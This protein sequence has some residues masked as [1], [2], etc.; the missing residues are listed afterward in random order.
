[1]YK[2]LYRSLLIMFLAL[3]PISAHAQW[4]V[5]WGSYDKNAFMT[6][7]GG[8]YDVVPGETIII[9]VH[10]NT[11]PGWHTY[12][13]NS[14]DSGLPTTVSWE[15]KPQDWRVSDILWPAPK[16]YAM[17][18]LVN[19][20]YEGK[21]LFPIEI[22]VPITA[23]WGEYA[24]KGRVD[25]LA[26]KDTCIPESQDFSFNLWVEGNTVTTAE[27]LELEMHH[28]NLPQ[29]LEGGHT[30]SQSGDTVT[31]DIDLSQTKLDH[32]KAKDIF[33]YPYET[34][35]DVIKNVMS[36]STKMTADRLSISAPIGE[37]GLDGYE[38]VTGVVT[39][40]DY[41]Y[42]ITA[43]VK[44]K[45]LSPL[46]VSQNQDRLQQRE[47]EVTHG[48]L[49]SGI[50]DTGLVFALGMALLGGIVLN[51]M[52]C[53]FPILSIKALGLVSLSG[54]E[55]SKMRLHGLAYMVGVLTCFA[56]L[57]LILILLKESGREIGWGIQ[58]Q[59]PIVVLYVSYI[60]FLVGYSLIGVVE[61]G[62][63]FANAGDRLAGQKGLKG[64][65]FTGALAVVVATP[66]TAPFMGTAVSYAL[67]QDSVVTF[68]VLMALGLGL[69][70]PYTLI[71]FIPAIARLLP[72]PGAWM[73][74]FKQFL[75]F[76]MFAAVVWLVWVLSQ[77]AGAAGVLLALAGLLLLAFAFW[78]YAGLTSLDTTGAK[79]WRG[80][81]WAVFVAVLA[82]ALYLPSQV[83][84]EDFCK[85]IN[86]EFTGGYETY[87][88]ET[89]ANARAEGRA[90]FVNMT[91][92]WCI[93]CLA[94]ERTTLS[95]SAVKQ[96]FANQ[97]V[98]YLK[99]DW[100]NRNP[101]I[102][103]FLNRY[104]RSGV[105]LYVY[106]PEGYNPE[107]EGIVLPQ[108]LTP[109]IVLDVLNNNDS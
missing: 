34:N 42:I 104:R 72:K 83:H 28:G 5:D 44:K 29:I 108:L 66:C 38:T 81:R 30:A 84:N 63:S 96:A 43:S 99:G 65:F 95:S 87:S 32:S 2:A 61:F 67:S 71:T 52:P 58:F 24:F 20:G 62:R 98:L 46:G 17:E 105:P 41:A 35:W 73:E 13:R 45:S 56:L 74:R 47:P 7:L 101:A 40:D 21:T 102:T 19:Y 25:W 22:E 11:R 70:L 68:L 91:A 9:G 92:S 85:A 76:L 33:F 3:I 97:D 69:A 75:G 106:Y 53:V 109:S 15:T 50:A 10:L 93:S 86:N 48:T 88:A 26:C 79:W 59:S 103:E 57:A 23:T 80:V 31:I 77:Q 18:D 89:L 90:V 107:G 12:W 54:K 16:R 14:G 39:L 100:T 55:K 60:L 82:W 1:M 4:D 64:S 51:L 6:L 36:Q 8:N 27:N 49:E 37:K 78:L 94:N